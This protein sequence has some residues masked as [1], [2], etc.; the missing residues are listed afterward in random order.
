LYSSLDGPDGKFCVRAEGDTCDADRECLS[1]RCD[2]GSCG[3]QNT[4]PGATVAAIWGR[5][6]SGG[7]DGEEPRF[8]YPIDLD[9]DLEG[10]T[11]VADSALHRIVKVGPDGLRLDAWG[12][13]GSGGADGNPPRFFHPAGV[14]VDAEGN[15]FVAD[16]DNHRVMKLS[17]EGLRLAAWGTEGSGGSDGNLPR[18]DRPC[19]VAVDAEGNFYVADTFNHRVLKLAPDGLRLAAWGSQGSGGSNGNSPRFDVPIGI[20]VDDNGNVYVADTNNDR[21]LKLSPAGLRLAA[22][23]SEG[24]KGA[25]VGATPRFQRPWDVTVDPDGNVFVTDRDNHRVQKLDPGGT[26]LAVWGRFGHGGTVGGLPQFDNPT[27]VAIDTLGNVY[28]SEGGN[29]RVQKLEQAF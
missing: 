26:I 1:Y 16:R 28:V 8:S 23:G 13:K 4:G 15:V 7:Q 20:V 14:A 11:F 19:G 18:F 22:W 5:D 9:V 27:G 25:E 17:P 10:N 24:S 3:A 12:S 2:G 6:G 21:V 29:V